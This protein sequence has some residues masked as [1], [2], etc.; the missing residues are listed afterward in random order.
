M[1]RARWMRIVFAG[2]AIACAACSAVLGLDAPP[3][4]VD[5]G[6]SADATTLG[7]GG[8]QVSP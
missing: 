3:G 5:A 8:R 4:P 7:D 6:G 2:A 1:A